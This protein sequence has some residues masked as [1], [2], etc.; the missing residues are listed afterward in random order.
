MI[1]GPRAIG[2]SV[3][4]L[5]TVLTIFMSEVILLRGTI[6]CGELYD[7]ISQNLNT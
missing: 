3:F 2:V 4:V 6:L 1:G 5:N 7:S